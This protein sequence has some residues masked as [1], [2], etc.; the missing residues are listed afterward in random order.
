LWEGVSDWKRVRKL[1]VV[2]KCVHMYINGNIIPVET[3][4]EIREVG[5]IYLIH[6]NILSKCHDALPPSIVKDQK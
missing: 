6:C 3:I 4:P 2:Q 1:N 5:M